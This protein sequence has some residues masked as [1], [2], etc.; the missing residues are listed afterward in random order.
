MAIN[1]IICD[2]VSDSPFRVQTVITV[3]LANVL[4]VSTD[5]GLASANHMH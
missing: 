1:I 2:L 3:K 4:Y 5:K